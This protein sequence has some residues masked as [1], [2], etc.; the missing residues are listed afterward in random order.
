M[1]PLSRPLACVIQANSM[2]GSP[3]LSRQNSGSWKTPAR[4]E[5]PQTLA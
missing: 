5:D 2:P 1:T 4:L 3:L